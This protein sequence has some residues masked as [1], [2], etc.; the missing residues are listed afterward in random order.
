MKNVVKMANGARRGSCLW[1]IFATDIYDTD[2]KLHFYFF[3]PQENPLQPAKLTALSN[4]YM[5][6]YFLIISLAASNIVFI[7]Y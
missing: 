5:M 7:Q 3:Q 6:Q 1:Q 2:T 4:Q